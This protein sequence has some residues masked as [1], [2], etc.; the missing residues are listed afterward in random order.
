M[1]LTFASQVVHFDFTVACFIRICFPECQAIDPATS[2]DHFFLCLQVWEIRYEQNVWV[3]P[4]PCKSGKKQTHC[5]WK[6]SHFLPQERFCLEPGEWV[7][8]VG[9]LME[10]GE[11]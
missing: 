7:S 6:N 4:K 3:L 5:D 8:S 11:R 2:T 1:D 10:L 9:Q